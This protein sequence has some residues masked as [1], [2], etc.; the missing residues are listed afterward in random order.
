MEHPALDWRAMPRKLDTGYWDTV[1][2]SPVASLQ[3]ASLLVAS[4]LGWDTA[5]CFLHSCTLHAALCIPQPAFLGECTWD[6]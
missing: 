3:V 4:S 2:S 1:A 6:E 5:F